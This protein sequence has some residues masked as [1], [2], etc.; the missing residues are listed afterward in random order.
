[1][2][3][4]TAKF[5]QDVL[6][7]GRLI[8][9]FVRTKS[10]VEYRTE[11]MLRL[12]V[13]REF[14]IVGEALTRAFKLELGAVQHLTGLRQIIGFRNVL[15]HGYSSIDDATVWEVTQVDLPILLREVQTL[16]ATTPAP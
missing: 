2:R 6:D 9:S 3:R 10:L 11:I 15:V 1:M 4:E 5:L 12:S 7:A 13:E 14:I 16:L 8:E